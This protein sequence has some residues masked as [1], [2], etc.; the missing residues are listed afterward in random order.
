[1][2]SNIDT[3]P[4]E[5]LERYIT[6]VEIEKVFKT[7]KDYTSLLPLAKWTKK[8]VDGKLF[9]EMI[10]TLVILL[11]RKKLIP[12]GLSLPDFTGKP[13]SQ[14]CFKNENGQVIIETPNKQVKELYQALDIKIPDYINLSDYLSHIT[15]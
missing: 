6:R 9:S 11:L 14:M 5:I 12:Q 7:G 15:G 10:S 3:D 8:R 13:K 1:M 4:A 2:I